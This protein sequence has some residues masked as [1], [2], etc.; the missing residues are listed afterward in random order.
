MNE[1]KNETKLR[2][3][4][5]KRWAQEE[6]KEQDQRNPW[7]VN[8]NHWKSGNLK[9]KVRLSSINRIWMQN[10]RRSADGALRSENYISIQIK[11]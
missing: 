2:R 9:L 7:S 6:G 3:R 4:N 5:S 1:G 10:I 11:K 8:C